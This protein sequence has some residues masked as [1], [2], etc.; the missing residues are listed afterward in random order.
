MRRAGRFVFIVLIAECLVLPVTGCAQKVPEPGVQKEEGATDTNKAAK[1]QPVSLEAVPEQKDVDNIVEALNVI[2][3]YKNWRD[4]QGALNRA[5]DQRYGYQGTD[6]FAFK[7]RKLD[8]LIRRDDISE[9][10]FDYTIYQLE[11]AVHELRDYYRDRGR[12]KRY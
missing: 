9:A 10:E 4:D 8:E 7:S 3:T 1:A 12:Y 5:L 2:V 11:E 6:P